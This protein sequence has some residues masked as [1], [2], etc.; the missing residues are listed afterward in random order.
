MQETDY[1]NIRTGQHV[2][3]KQ[4]LPANG[5]RLGAVQYWAG[6]VSEASHKWI[7]VKVG[8]TE[9]IIPQQGQERFYVVSKKEHDEYVKNFTMEEHD[10]SR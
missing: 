1:G 6:K 2:I 10:D 7:K 9:H 8:K 4:V 5:A 3:A